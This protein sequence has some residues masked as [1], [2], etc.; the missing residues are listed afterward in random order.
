MSLSSKA[1]RTVLKLNNLTKSGELVWKGW[2]YPIDS[3]SVVEEIGGNAFIASVLEKRFRIYKYTVRHYN[4][5]D[6][7]WDRFPRIR[8][9]FIDEKAKGGWEF[10]ADDRIV[11]LMETILFK[12][13][14]ASEFFDG[15]LDN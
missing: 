7:T 6:D 9:E 13:S 14:G 4:A 10:P 12:T 1:S 3:L 8:L 15:F 11:D 2:L 5:D